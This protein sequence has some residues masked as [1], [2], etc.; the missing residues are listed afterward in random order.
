MRKYIYKKNDRDNMEKKPLF[1]SKKKTIYL[2]V[3]NEIVFIKI[4][5]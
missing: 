3:F 2:V 5:L 4:S 1:K